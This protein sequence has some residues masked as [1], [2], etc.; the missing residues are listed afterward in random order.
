MKY[1]QDEA[2]EFECAREAIDE[3]LGLP[4]EEQEAAFGKATQASIA[5]T[6]A[7]GLPT[8]HGDDKGIYQIFPDGHKEYIRL[9]T[10]E[11]LDD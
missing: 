1:T 8:T 3:F 7:L 5:K 2:I 11:G 9:Y 4:K 10:K 6:H